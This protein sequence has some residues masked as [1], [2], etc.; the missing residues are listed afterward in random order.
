[1]WHLPP[2]VELSVLAQLERGAPVE[3]E[4]ASP[5]PETDKEPAPPVVPT[6]EERAAPPAQLTLIDPVALEQQRCARVIR[7]RAQVWKA[8]KT[9]A[10]RLV[11][12]ALEHAA[13]EIEEA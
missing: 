12:D 2:E 11:A 7:D 8:N 13:T 4:G 1:L 3:L 10:G 5:L 6:P 9:S